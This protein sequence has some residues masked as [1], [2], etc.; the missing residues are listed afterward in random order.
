MLEGLWLGIAD[1]PKQIVEIL[2]NPFVFQEVSIQVVEVNLSQVEVVRYISNNF[3]NVF[4]DC[5]I[6]VLKCKQSR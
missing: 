2:Q 4:D 1:Q 5:T 6:T 3:E